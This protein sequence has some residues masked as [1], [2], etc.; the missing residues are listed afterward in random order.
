[1]TGARRGYFESRGKMRDE[2][3]AGAKSSSD[4]VEDIGTAFR[5]DNGCPGEPFNGIARMSLGAGFCYA[6]NP[7]RTPSFV[8]LTALMMTACQAHPPA[9]WV[10]GGS[11][12]SPS[13]PVD[14]RRAAHRHHARR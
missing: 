4:H 5:I 12:L 3:T 9:N 10:Q 8:A 2:Q 13:R 11:P 7:M 14:T 6:A 1:M